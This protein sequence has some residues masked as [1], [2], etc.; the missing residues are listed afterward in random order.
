VRAPWKSD[1]LNIAPG[2][3][4]DGSS[5][6]LDWGS[7]A[8]LAGVVLREPSRIAYMPWSALLSSLLR[9]LDLGDNGKGG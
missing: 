7:C 2:E 9:V 5:N 1:T 8:R 3:R 4:W 6:A